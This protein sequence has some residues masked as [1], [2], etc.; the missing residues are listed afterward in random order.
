MD[1][2]NSPE[3][4]HNLLHLAFDGD[5]ERLREFR[6]RLQAGLPAGCGAVLRGSSVT[7]QRWEGG[8]FD[9]KGP[10]TSDLDIA[11]VGEEALAAFEDFYVPGV[12]SSPLN[13]EH[14]ERAP[15]LD[16]HRRAMQQ[17]AGRPVAVQATSNWVLFVRDHIFGQPYFTLF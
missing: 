6:E 7:N 12:H 5:A 10:G 11:L 9:E 16:A 2:T 14:P 3:A 1:L 17:L 15:S 13:D 4:L 8:T